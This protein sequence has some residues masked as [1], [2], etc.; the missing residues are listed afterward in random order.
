MVDWNSNR[1]YGYAHLP[2][3]MFSPVRVSFGEADGGGIEH[4]PG[5]TRHAL[6]RLI[7]CCRSID[8]SMLR[9]PRRQN[10]PGGPAWLPIQA[11]LNLMTGTVISFSTG[12]VLSIISSILSI[13]FA[14]YSKRA[15]RRD[16]ST[17]IPL[18]SPRG[19][20]EILQTESCRGIRI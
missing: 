15:D 3:E 16:V 4:S 6:R 1:T 10:R 8:F 19:A 14:S 17:G 2:P 20:Q 5:N 13:T 9:M 12:F 11:T 18:G 7:R